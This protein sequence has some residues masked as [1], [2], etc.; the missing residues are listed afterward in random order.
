[1]K[2]IARLMLFVGLAVALYGCSAKEEE[3]TQ[4]TT[5]PNVSAEGKEAAGGGAD[6]RPKFDPNGG[7]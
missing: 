7:Q 3:S 1:M 6:A 2:T 4:P 5:A